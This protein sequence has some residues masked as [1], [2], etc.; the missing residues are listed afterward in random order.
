MAGT[1]IARGVETLDLGIEGMSCAACVG[2]VERALTAV[3]GVAGAAVNLATG[4]ARVTLVPGGASIEGLIGA[5]RAAGYAAVPVAEIVTH[6]EAAEMAAQRRAL[7]WAAGLSLPLFVLEMGG[8]MVPA[9]HHWLMGLVEARMLYG[10][11]FL[12]ATAVLVGP[13]RGFFTKG[14]PALI[15]LAPDMNAL[16][17]LGAGAAWLYSTVVVFAPGILPEG[18]RHVYFEAA[19][20]IVTL[21]LLGRYLEARARGRTGAAITRLVGLSAKTAR[22]IRDGAEIELPVAEV[23]L[24][25]VL[26]VRPGEKIAVDGVVIEGGSFVDEAMISGEPAPV[27][28]R[29]GAEVIGA[30][31]NGTGSFTYRATRVGAET[32]LARITRMV[33]EAQGDKLPIQALVDRVTLWF[34]PAVIVAA[35]VTFGVW[36]VFGPEPALALA[37]VNA[38]AVLIVACP[39]AMGLATPTSILVGSGRG[40]EMGILFRR[41]AAL[42]GLSGVDVVAFDKTGT[43]TEGRPRLTDLELAPGFE[44]DAVLALVAAAEAGS[45]HPVAG[46]LVA[47]ARAEG[48]EPPAARDFAAVPG[49][50]VSARVGERMVVVG[51]D[52]YLERL[53][54]PVGAFASTAARLGSLGRTPLYVAVDGRLAAVLAVADAVKPS[55]AATVAALKDLGL[56]VAMVT[57]DNAR[58]ARAIAGELGIDTVVAEVLPGEKVAAVRDLRAGGRKVAFVGDG[59]NDAPALAEADVGIAVGTG[60]DIAIESADVVLISGDLGNVVAALGLSRAVMANIRTNLFWAFAYNVALIPVAAG[61]LYPGFGVLMS[62]V[63]AAGAMAVSSVCVVGNALRLRRYR[64]VEGDMA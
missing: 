10:L 7:L 30:T 54:I 59:I 4:R 1:G 52:R 48:I 22:V 37:I 56:R 42:Q 28:K 8:H 39:C 23:V 29:P 33:E 62:P 9:F 17:M 61:V 47:A 2:R 15:G 40:A 45:E 50:G 58:A 60:T 46:A 32:M 55:T 13:G 34:V 63:L 18:A 49:M 27:E 26:R 64:R 25:D 43:L 44:R 12:L 51:A 19:A 6:D 21:I 38:V 3:P 20:V 57:G 36:M 31:I 5:A 41:G 14:W 35:G 24:G 16:V 11:Q 53:G